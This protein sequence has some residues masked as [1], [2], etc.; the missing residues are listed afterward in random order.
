MVKT[1]WVVTHERVGVSMRLGMGH[2]MNVTGPYSACNSLTETCDSCVVNAGDSARS[3]NIVFAEQEFGPRRIVAMCGPTLI[4]RP[5]SLF[6]L[7]VIVLIATLIADPY[8]TLIV[9]AFD[10]TSHAKSPHA[11]RLREMDRAHSLGVSNVVQFSRSQ[12]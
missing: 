7:I 10:E 4:L 8:R 9:V 12:T 6:I 3:G 11:R 2:R 5:L 1:C